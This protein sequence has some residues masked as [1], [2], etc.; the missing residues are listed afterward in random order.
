MKAE[1][2]AHL[3]SARKIGQ[4][5]RTHCPCHD[6]K[7]PSL[8]FR[9]GE[10]GIVYACRSQ[11]CDSSEIA[12]AFRE[13]FADEL[14]SASGSQAH[15]KLVAPESKIVS[16]HTYAIRDIE[17]K[18]IAEHV[19]EDLSDGAKRFHWRRNGLPGLGGLPAADLPLYR[20]EQLKRASGSVLI[21]EGEKAADAGR[22]LGLL[23]LGTVTGAAGTHSPTVL[24]KLE[25]RPVYLSADNDDPGRA[26]MERHAGALQG[27]A[28]AVHWLDL[29]GL[30][31]RGDLADW[32]SAGRTRDQLITLMESA[33]VWSPKAGAESALSDPNGAPRKKGAEADG[34]P[35]AQGKPESVCGHFDPAL[36]VHISVLV[37]EGR[38]IQAEGVRYVVEGLV[39]DYGMVGFI[40]GCAKVGKSTTGQALM[41][42]VAKGEDFLGLK[43]TQRPVLYLALEDPREYIA[44]IAARTFSGGEDAI[45]YPVP[46]VLNELA[47]AGLE[48]FV[49]QHGVGFLYVATFLAGVRGLVDDENDNAGMANIVGSLK[50]F[51]RR[52]GKPVLL[53]AHAGKAEDLSADADPVKA[54]RG[55]SSAAA[56]ADFLL[57]IKREGRGGFTTKRTLSGLGRFVTAAPVTFDYDH[58]TGSLTYLGEAGPSAAA[59]TDWR[60]IQETG[61]LALEYRAAS[62]I[63]IAARFMKAGAK[64]G[65][66]TRARARVAAALF[67]REGVQGQDNGEA[68]GRR[69][70]YYRLAGESEGPMRDQG[71]K[72]DPTDPRTLNGAGP[73]KGVR[74][75]GLYGP[76]GPCGPSDLWASGPASTLGEPAGDAGDRPRETVDL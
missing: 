59:E 39:P 25:G 6:D 53:E 18:L 31:P 70:I 49:K 20:M 73:P 42:A 13:K 57:S 10:K 66:A 23:T 74:P 36:A 65:E 4:E 64:G 19:R 60:L 67:Q 12:R 17:G 40:V 15:A 71:P 8:D 14:W 68:R 75:L 69:R 51:A 61:A 44:W 34:V 3:E 9:D 43:T 7:R 46:I 48:D 32:V 33:P 2:L 28:A 24:A 11:G 52:I 54:L 63:A 29:P 35:C 27:I 58:E 1:H 47:L 21:V 76:L 26:H 38:R 16:S 45:V 55:A 72:E 37:E 41:R 50:A 22:S 5:W 62:A 30:G 56:E